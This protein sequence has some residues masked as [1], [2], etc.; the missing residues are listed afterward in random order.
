LAVRP[1]LDDLELELVQSVEADEHQVRAQHS[2]PGLEGDFLQALG[3]RAERVTITGVLTV[4]DKEEDAV[5]EKLKK[6]REKFR[7]AEP[8]AFVADI[9]T[10]TKLDTVLIEEM[11]VREL[12]GKPQRFE[13]AFTLR[14]Y[15]PAPPPSEEPPPPPP[16]PPETTLIVEVIVQGQPSFDFSKVKVRVEGQE[17]SGAT[18]DRE[19]TNRANNVWTENDFPPG[20]YTARA[21]VT[22]PPPMSGAEPAVVR[23]GQKTKVTIVLQAGT[24]RAVAKAFVV[25]FRFDKA[26]IEPCQRKI[27]NRV[28]RYAAEHP[29]E[30]LV[31]VGHTDRSGSDDYNLSLGDRRARS[32]YAYLNLGNDRPG[33]LA[34]WDQIRRPQTGAL[35][36]LQDHWGTLQY[37]YMLEDLGFL[38]GNMD[39]VHGAATD[40]AV[41]DFRASAG[42]PP[43]TTVDDAVWAALIERYHSQEPQ[44]V[45]AGQFLANADPAAGCDGGPLKWLSC[46]EQ[47]PLP[48]TPP[49]PCA[50]GTAWRPNRRTELLFVT[51]TALPCRVPPPVTFN[52]PAP[53]AVSPSWCLGPGNPAQRACFITRDPNATGNRWLIEPA[54]PGTLTVTG[55]IRRP[56]GTPLGN[57]RFV[58]VAPDGE[59]MR[60][61]TTGV[62]GDG[63][64]LCQSSRG[65]PIPARTRPDGTFDYSG[66][67]PTPVGVYTME[68][69]LPNGPHVAHLATRPPSTGR[70]S[71]VCTRLDA[72]NSVFDVIVRDGPASAF[73]VQPNI[74]VDNSIVI[75]KKPSNNPARRRVTLSADQAF[76]GT[77]LFERSSPSVRFFSAAAGGTEIT[78]NGTDNVFTGAQLNA[79]VALF[80][81]GAAPSA[82]IDDITLTLTLRS[83]TSLVRPPATATLTS[84]ELTLDICVTR[85]NPGTDPA[86]LSAADK[87]SPG[88]TVQVRDVTL[89]H[90]RA[91]LIVRPPNPVVPVTLELVPISAEVQA[92]TDEVPAA[93]QTPL[94]NPHPMAAGA[95]P[96][97][98][99]RFFAEGLTPSAAPRS[100]GFRLGIQALEPDGDGVRVTTAQLEVTA[101]ADNVTPGLRFVRFGLWDQAYDAAEEVRTG[102]TEATHF[103]GNDA[104]KFHFR[105]R[106]TNQTGSVNVDWRTVRAD[107]TTGDDAPAAPNSAALTLVETPAASKV[108]LSRSV[109]LVVDDLNKV[110]TQSGL[111]APLDTGVRVSGQS[112]HR[113]RRA[114]IDGFLRVEYAPQAG[115]RLGLTASVFDRAVP[116]NTT[117]AAAIAAGVQVVTPAAMSVRSN[118]VLCTI[119][120]GSSLTIDTGATQETVVVTAVTATTFTATFAQAHAAPVA[121]AGTADERRRVR[122]RVVRYSNA[123][124]P[125]FRVATNAYI[126][127]QFARANLRW[128]QIGFQIDPG[129]TEDRPIPAGALLAG[130]YPFVPPLGN[131]P[132]QTAIFADILPTTPDNT[133]TALFM[134]L[135]GANAYAAIAAI[136]PDPT[137]IPL[138]APIAQADRFF[139]FMHSALDLRDE[140]L[141]HELHHVLFNRFDTATQRRFFTLNTRPPLAWAA[142]AA[143]PIA[144]PDVRIYWRIQ[145]QNSADVNNDPTNANVINWP[146]RRRTA[147]LGQPFGFAAADGTTGNNFS[148][149]F[150]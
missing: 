96:A 9:A 83:T 4:L 92:F 147:R 89:S 63:E 110:A 41:Q 77:G 120:V 113:L 128:N 109:M 111:S 75:V 60:F 27:L 101:L 52:L 124:D 5:S 127:A 108:F 136:V 85:P 61:P 53:G 79:G 12:A 20:S 98:G 26:F 144:L 40:T 73:A 69:E 122:C 129:P 67:A 116:F 6:L 43:G 141:A 146:R 13:Y 150:S 11:S 107:R 59:F 32:V 10:A 145:N 72:S 139:M 103:I 35:P 133:L 125:T 65:T 87:F 48:T 39:G 17:E 95:V 81:E 105:L 44:A 22:D 19:L 131:S 28:A 2:V 46:G 3:R 84:V 74:A 37:Q 14:E 21:V 119:K 33:S 82:A 106:D 149:D 76:D 54:E 7:A 86:P 34:E 56:D 15:I 137:P 134:D 31:I 70:G 45:P 130:K 140:T 1:M 138:G 62:R 36:T 93:G 25:T 64:R 16:P 42:L 132:Q 78:F 102:A 148:E 142:A 115:V 57:T 58:L 23:E 104:R 51:D 118:G 66:R 126:A 123:A 117:A 30:K 114:R 99:L 38:P 80:A 90:E 91:M 88:R 94:P 47:M 71:V 55:L 112:N 135:T 8:V 143:P 121:I 29:D 97:A 68:V 24:T 49:A 50:P 100:T 18:L